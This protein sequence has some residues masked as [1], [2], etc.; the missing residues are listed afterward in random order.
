MRGGAGSQDSGKRRNAG[1][2]RGRE[3]R[4]KCVG[5]V[6]VCVRACQLGACEYVERILC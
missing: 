6:F 5:H 4:L 1:T 3:D 2:L